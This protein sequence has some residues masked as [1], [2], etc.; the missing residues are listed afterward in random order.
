M[1]IT[2]D[3]KRSTWYSSRALKSPDAYRDTDN[4]ATIWLCAEKLAT[5]T[6]GEWFF[7]WDVPG[8][9]SVR[10]ILRIEQDSSASWFLRT[11][12]VN[13]AELQTMVSGRDGHYMKEYYLGRLSL[14]RRQSLEG[15]AADVI[16]RE[17]QPIG[18]ACDWAKYVFETCIKSGWFHKPHAREVWQ[19]AINQ[20]DP[21][22]SE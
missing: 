14:L 16:E 15:L 12:C 21:R 1:P 10:R 22:K 13:V 17:T 5:A 7:A 18:C 19:T 8:L 11:L 4:D 3:T 2:E 9:P 6:T 20:N